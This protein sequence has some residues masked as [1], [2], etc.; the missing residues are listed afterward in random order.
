M[1]NKK[2]IEVKADAKDKTAKTKSLKASSAAPP[3]PPNVVTYDFA[4]TFETRLILVVAGL[5]SIHKRKDGS[6]VFILTT[7]DCHGS[8]VIIQG[9][10]HAA[11]IL[12][13]MFE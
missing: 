1:D 6:E 5:G 2:S 3:S 11:N 10:G 7:F 9:W 8:K 12:L 13:S 4:D